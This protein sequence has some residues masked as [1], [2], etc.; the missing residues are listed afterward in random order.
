MKKRGKK[1]ELLNQKL[2]LYLYSIDENKNEIL[3]LEN[4]NKI[5]DNNLK[6]EI[7]FLKGIRNNN[8]GLNNLLEEN[9]SNEM[10]FNI[11]REIA[12]YYYKRK[13]YIECWKNLEYA[14]NIENINFIFRQRAIIDSSFNLKKFFENNCYEENELISINENIILTKDK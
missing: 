5:F 1:Y 3:K 6:I 11:Y 4:N 2:L 10:K 12:I 7:N 13:N 9:I 14:I 8:E